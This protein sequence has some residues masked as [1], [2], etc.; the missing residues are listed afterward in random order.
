MKK[1]SK[2][3]KQIKKKIVFMKAKPRLMTVVKK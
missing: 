2:I 3:D 1:E